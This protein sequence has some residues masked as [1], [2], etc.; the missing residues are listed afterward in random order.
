[1]GP[2]LGILLCDYFV[3]RKRTLQVAELYKTDGIYAYGGSGINS[4]AVIA[5]LIGVF[6]AMI[7]YWVKPL[8]F[9][10][11]LSWFS[12]TAVAFVVYLVLMRRSL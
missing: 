7:G 12:G 9:L 3:I 11:T 5:L 1:L 10:S 6:V 8:E 2:V 4:A